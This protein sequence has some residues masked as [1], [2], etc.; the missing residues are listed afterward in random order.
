MQITLIRHGKTAGNLLHRY[1]GKTDEPLC[2]EG[3]AEATAHEKDLSLKKVYVSPLIRTQQT[4][5]ILFPNAQQIIID[6]LREMDFGIFENRSADEMADDKEYRAWVEG[7]CEGTCPKGE[8]RADFV[9]R[10]FSA[11]RSVVENAEDDCVFVVHGG[12]VMAIMS[13]L[14]GGSFYDFYVPNLG[15][16]TFEFRG[17]GISD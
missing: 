3:I 17:A 1:I 15:E 5:Q 13:E 11:F 12:T 10:T 14:K 2:A 9:K 4:A 8:C 7:M 16:Y 6:D